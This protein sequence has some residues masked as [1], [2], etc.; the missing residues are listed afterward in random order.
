MEFRSAHRNTKEF[1]VVRWCVARGSQSV[2]AEKH[3]EPSLDVTSSIMMREEREARSDRPF[4]GAHG[5]SVWDAAASREWRV[6][7]ADCRAVPG[8]RRDR[9]LIFDC[10]TTV[11][12]VWSYPDDWARLSDD[13]LLAIL[14]APADR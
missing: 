4:A 5:R 6:W 1:R 11:R 10:G 2:A 7:A 12:R 8:H 13:A 14:D 9:C 3:L